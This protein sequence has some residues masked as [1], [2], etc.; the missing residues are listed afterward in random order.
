M[1]FTVET[2]LSIA[3][4]GASCHILKFDNSIKVLLDCGISPRFDFSK[5]HAKSEDIKSV[6]LVLISHSQL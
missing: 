6:S 4:D 5:Y 3:G 1:K 2:I